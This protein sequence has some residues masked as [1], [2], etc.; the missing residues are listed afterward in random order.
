MKLKNFRHLW[1][2]FTSHC[3]LFSVKVSHFPQR[4][5]TALHTF[6]AT[7]FLCFFI[8]FISLQTTSITSIFTFSPL[9]SLLYFSLNY[10]SSFLTFHA[11]SLTFRHFMRSTGVRSLRVQSCERRCNVSLEAPH[12][13]ER[14]RTS[15][16]CRKRSGNSRVLKFPDR[17]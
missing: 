9:P 14:L 13:R 8:P 15:T 12:D 6:Q 11:L 7:S 16:L 17:T 1:D 3:F 4:K 5:F 10:F 2:F